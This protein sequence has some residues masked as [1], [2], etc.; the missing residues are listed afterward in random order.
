M[1]PASQERGPLPVLTRG[2]QPAPLLFKGW[3]NPPVE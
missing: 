3:K 2:P 1:R